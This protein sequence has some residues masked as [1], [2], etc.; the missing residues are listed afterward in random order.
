[1]AICFDFGVALGEKDGIEM[2]W[3]KIGSD[4]ITRYLQSGRMK[5]R[6]HTGN[7]STIPAL[8]GTKAPIPGLDTTYSVMPVHTKWKQANDVCISLKFGSL[9]MAL[10]VKTIPIVESMFI[11]VHVRNFLWMC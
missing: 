2:A 11:A 1:M 7:I 5:M 6:Q 10:L 9:K 3:M 4:E 8:L